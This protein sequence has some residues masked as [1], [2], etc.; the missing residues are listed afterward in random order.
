LRSWRA[1]FPH[2]VRCSSTRTW[3]CATNEPPSHP[4]LAPAQ[5]AEISSDRSRNP[6]VASTDTSSDSGRITGKQEVIPNSE[7]S[8]WEVATFLSTCLCPIDRPAFAGEFTS[9]R[10]LFGR[11]RPAADASMY[12]SKYPASVRCALVRPGVLE[13]SER[14]ALSVH[15]GEQP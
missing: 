3:R 10:T 12:A 14:E 1:T 2:A 8:L 7:G 5:G 11:S 13:S 6:T 9:P 15:R 4:R